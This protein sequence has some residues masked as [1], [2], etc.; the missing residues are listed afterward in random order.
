M[1]GSHI[2]THTINISYVLYFPIFALCVLDSVEQTNYMQNACYELSITK[3]VHTFF[4]EQS[5]E[6]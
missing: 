5:Y 1:Q 2:N 6:K 3:K 4:N